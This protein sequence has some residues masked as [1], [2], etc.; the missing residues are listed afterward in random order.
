MT[1][2]SPQTI[3]ALKS[4]IFDWAS[5]EM[6]YP[7]EALDEANATALQIDNYVANM[8]VDM[9]VDPEDSA[10][11]K[12]HFPQNR[13]YLAS[14][15]V[16]LTGLINA[17]CE[18]AP[19]IE[20]LH[21]RDLWSGMKTLPQGLV[22]NT[23]LKY[24]EIEGFD[25]LERIDALPPGLKGFYCKA[26]ENI[27]SLPSQ[28]PRGLKTLRVAC[29]KKLSE[30]TGLPRGLEVF[31]VLSCR[32]LWRLQD[33]LPNSLLDIMFSSLENLQRMPDQGLRRLKRIYIIS[34]DRLTSEQAGPVLE[35]LRA[36]GC[37]LAGSQRTL[38]RLCSAVV[39][40]LPLA[41][42]A[43]SGSSGTTVATIPRGRSRAPPTAGSAW[44]PGDGVEVPFGRRDGTHGKGKL[45]SGQ[46]R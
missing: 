34:C 29:C 14:S 23:T 22:R 45:T 39:N 30:I 16:D 42:P 4:K 6:R 26:N 41:S 2:P 15:H 32:N 44:V 3:A 9:P 36:G 11:T 28:W 5:S 18:N 33:S 12:E 38:E 31:H 35:R 19:W 21:L 10:Y 37:D 25:G 1:K 7:Q 43:P 17:V 13:V 27:T 40:T 20:A 8:G 46:R 24:L